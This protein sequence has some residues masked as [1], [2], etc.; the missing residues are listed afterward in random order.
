MRSI[1]Q[2]I[3]LLA[4][5]LKDLLAEKPDFLLPLLRERVGVRAASPIATV[6]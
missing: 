2:A 5:P 1:T 4:K 3:A 6:A